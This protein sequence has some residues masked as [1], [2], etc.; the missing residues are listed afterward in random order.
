MFPD[1]M[2]VIFF[3]FTMFQAHKTGQMKSQYF[4]LMYLWK[5]VHKNFS[6]LTCTASAFCIRNFVEKGHIK[7][8]AEEIDTADT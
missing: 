4:L 2:T 5:E 8:V 3:D 1:Q 7:L 6:L